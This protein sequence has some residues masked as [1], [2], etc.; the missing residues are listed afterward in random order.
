MYAAEVLAAAKNSVSSNLNNKE[1]LLPQ[2]NSKKEGILVYA[3]I[4]IRLLR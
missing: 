2:R 3:F 1:L 4:F